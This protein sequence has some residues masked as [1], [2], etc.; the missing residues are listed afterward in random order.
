MYDIGATPLY[1]FKPFI[2]WYVIEYSEV[3]MACKINKKVSFNYY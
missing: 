3:S 2:G 1:V